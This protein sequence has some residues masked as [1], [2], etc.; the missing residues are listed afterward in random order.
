MGTEET[1][2]PSELDTKYFPPSVF[3]YVVLY[4]CIWIEGPSRFNKSNQSET[5]L[6]EIR[7]NLRIYM[8]FSRYNNIIF[9]STDKLCG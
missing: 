4:Q 1:Q 6:A 2:F 8:L 9:M 3:G 7:F 5:L